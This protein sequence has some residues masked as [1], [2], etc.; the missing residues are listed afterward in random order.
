VFVFEEDDMGER[1]F[2]I[3][4]EEEGAE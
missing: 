4:A 3:V 2:E 1:A